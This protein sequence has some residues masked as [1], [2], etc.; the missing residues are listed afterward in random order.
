LYHVEHS[1]LAVVTGMTLASNTLADIIA[2][3]NS[4]GTPIVLVAETGAW[5]A[6]E[7]RD[8]YGI[9]SVVAEPFPFYIFSGPSEINLYRKQ[10]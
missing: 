8:A 6:P 10:C 4:S 7:Y 9:H 3:A 1:D 5:F 2:V